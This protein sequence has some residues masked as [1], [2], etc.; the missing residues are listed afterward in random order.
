MSRIFVSHS[1]RDAEFAK[2]IITWL[3]ANGFDEVFLDFDK[4]SGIAVGDDWERRLYSEVER[5]HAMIIVATPNWHTSKWCWSEFTQARALGKGIFPIIEKAA[6][7]L[8]VSPDIQ[9]IDLTEDRAAGLEQ[10]L[11]KLT[12]VTLKVQGGFPWDINRPPFPGLLSFEEEDA[13]VYFGRDDE[14][15]KLIERLNARRTQ[16]GAQLMALLG[17][18]G[19]GKSSML[20]AG[21]I[22]RLK[23]ARRT[24]II[25][26]PFRPQ[27]SPI[28]ELATSLAIALG[29]AKSWRAVRDQLCSESVDRVFQDL[30]R[31]LRL[32]AGANEA[33]ILIPIDQA[34]ELF[35][36]TDAAEAQ[37]FFELL[38][39]ALT[40]RLP[41]LAVMAIRSDYLGL[42]Q[43]VKALTSDFEQ[44][45]LRPLPS[46]RI[47]SIIEGPAQVTGVHVDDELVRQ[48]TKDAETDDALPLLAFTLRELYDQYGQDQHLSIADYQALGDPNQN[49]NPLE[50]A[51]R[52]AADAIITDAQPTLEQLSALREAFVP[53]LVRI[54]E[55]GDYVRRSAALDTLPLLAQPLIERFVDARL[56]VIRR[57]GDTRVVEV[58]HEA[59]LRKWPLLRSWLDE[60][61]E[62]LI[63]K[64]RL[65]QDLQDWEHAAPDRKEDA[66]LSGL[67]LERARDW[68][69]NHPRQL[70][71]QERLFIKASIAREEEE[72]RRRI[73]EKEFADRQLTWQ[74]SV[75]ADYA[76]AEAETG[77]HTNAVLLALEALPDEAEGIIRPH[78]QRAHDALLS[79]LDE[80]RERTILNSHFSNYGVPKFTPD[81]KRLVTW[82][83][84][85]PIRLWDVETGQILATTT[86]KPD[87]SGHYEISA[88]SARLVTWFDDDA[89]AA[90]WN[91]QSGELIASLEAHT[92]A[93]SN[94]KFADDTRIVVTASRDKT[95][96]V[97][98]A[99]TGAHLNA[100]STLYAIYRPH[101]IPNSK[102]VL[103]EFFSR[104]GL[105]LLD[106]DSGENIAHIPYSGPSTFWF[107]VSQNG[108][109]IVTIG[110]NL[111]TVWDANDGTIV[112][113]LSGHEDRINAVSIDPG[114]SRVVTASDDKTVRVWNAHTGGLIWLSDKHRHKVQDAVFSA[115]GSKLLS[116]TGE[117]RW[118]DSRANGIYVWDTSSGKLL[119]ELRAEEEEAI[120]PFFNNIFT[121][122]DQDVT[123]VVTFHKSAKSGRSQVLWNVESGEP[124]E[125]FKITEVSLEQFS[126]DGT[127]LIGIAKDR[128]VRIMNPHN[129][130]DVMVLRGHRQLH[131]DVDASGDAVLSR[132]GRYL[133]TWIWDNTVRIWDMWGTATSRVMR[134]VTGNLE[135]VIYPPNGD[136]ERALAYIEDSHR[137]HYGLVLVDLEHETIVNEIWYE[138]RLHPKYTSDTRLL[139]FRNGSKRL[140]LCKTNNLEPQWTLGPFEADVRHFLLYHNETKILLFLESGAVLI[141]DVASGVCLT[142]FIPEHGEFRY[143]NEISESGIA[144]TIDDAHH[145]YVWNLYEK[146]LLAD[147][148]LPDRPRR[149]TPVSMHHLIT[150]FEDREAILWDMHS[151]ERILQMAGY[152]DSNGDSQHIL[153]DQDE[154]TVRSMR[155]GREVGRLAMPSIVG[156]MFVAN[157]GRILVL[158]DLAEENHAVFTL[159]DWNTG[160]LKTLLR[161]PRMRYSIDR[162]DEHMIRIR[163]QSEWAWHSLTGE[164]FPVQR[165]EKYRSRSKEVRK[166]FITS[167]DRIIA[168]TTLEVVRRHADLQDLMS[169]A[170]QA[171]PRGLTPQER[172]TFKL[173]AIPPRWYVTMGKWP[174]NTPDWMA[175]QEA[176]DRGENPEPPNTAQ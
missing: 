107:V 81:S 133:A 163:G 34:E 123:K 145:L 27:I 26:P 155:D 41:Y 91:V 138:E 21:V 49:L 139:V 28:D 73:A 44:F 4:H 151:G 2:G 46:T 166:R 85:G 120:G 13:A 159:W 169:H 165:S 106:I 121:Y 158:Q 56:L 31:D 92:E 154:L 80:Q 126:P 110:D 32:N 103:C 100:I 146:R 172:K 77:N 72:H 69:I 119:T 171:V 96:H 30:S 161:G 23:R 168:A 50:N 122:F 74:S 117:D 5:C 25:L 109:L 89:T 149:V 170:K 175:F 16:G 108:T 51:V 88:D 75:L 67:K 136:A 58:A 160:E 36:V 111:A 45:S 112:A 129:G 97:W 37:R 90:L 101:M 174:Y 78:V 141:I 68:L 40:P 20:R 113:T 65:E 64:K 118:E 19:S 94:A 157:T 128:S 76:Q 10:L 62:F 142:R 125:R 11:R 127:F 173:D 153:T 130:K 86:G 156:A 176:S 18:S 8:F 114:S 116:A 82:E 55:D 98:D 162:L 17:A 104:K 84:S 105:L 164:P 152:M 95:L 7:E 135:N 24:W 52:K 167:D 147:I 132:D 102:R 35:R 137:Q 60:Q 93:I 54:G 131:R 22:P 115:D 53:A 124:I 144:S 3:N 6:N 47:P 143:M 1:S 134:Y 38:N 87:K 83:A 43:S 71:E 63:G 39:S 59:L 9:H 57:D 66:L 79:A 14:T 12:E 42:L 29:D 70:L 140:Q 48:A 148:E 15:R 61:W 33:H 99:K 150:T